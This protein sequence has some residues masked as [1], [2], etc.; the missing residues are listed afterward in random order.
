MNTKSEFH[1]SW[2]VRI[3]A[4]KGN[5]IEEQTGVDKVEGQEEGEGAGPGNIKL[6]K[7]KIYRSHF[8]QLWVQ[9]QK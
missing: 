9:K 1:H 8:T 7:T 4:V 3:V 5:L 6:G 2:I